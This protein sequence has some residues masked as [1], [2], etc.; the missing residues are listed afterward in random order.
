MRL[1]AGRE[2]PPQN[3]APQRLFQAVS[4]FRGV[5]A[6]ERARRFSEHRF[7]AKN[8]PPLPLPGCTMPQSCECKYLKHRDRRGAQRRLTDYTTSRI[9]AGVERRR[10]KGR[11]ATD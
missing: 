8:A 3:A 9:Y 11:R 1:R 2:E 4:I 7:L 10:L 6:C 5:N